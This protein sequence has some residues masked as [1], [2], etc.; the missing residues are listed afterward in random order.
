MYRTILVHRDPAVALTFP[1]DGCL[2]PK[3]FLTVLLPHPRPQDVSEQDCQDD[4]Y[5][6][7]VCEWA[8]HDHAQEPADT[9]GVQQQERCAYDEY[10]LD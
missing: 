3:T 6:V 4:V 7:V 10:D 9:Y 2:A 1:N 8:S 5:E